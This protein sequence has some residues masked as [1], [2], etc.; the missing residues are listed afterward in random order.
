MPGS[1]KKI[2]K[3]VKKVIKKV[4]RKRVVFKAPHVSGNGSYTFND[5]KKSIDKNIFNSPESVGVVNKAARS[6][7]EFFGNKIHPVAGKV[8]GNA[9]SWLSRV[10][11]FGAYNIKSNSLARDGQMNISDSGGPSNIPE[12]RS[13]TKNSVR[14]RHR[15][16]VTDIVPTA[17]GFQNNNYLIHAGNVLL[18]PWL[19]NMS[20]NF[21]VAQIHGMIIE[22]KATCAT[23]VSSAQIGMGTVIMAT[24]YDVVDTAYA[25]KREMEIC[26]FATS[27]QPYFSQIHPIECD[28]HENVLSKHYIQY[29][30]TSVSDFPDD[31][32]FGC[33]GNFQIATNNIP[34]LNQAIGELWVSYDVEFFKPQLPGSNSLL[35]QTATTH[36]AYQVSN[37][38]S[39]SDTQILGTK[40]QPAIVAPL[41]VP[42]IANPTA[43]HSQI[44][45]TFGTPGDYMVTFQHSDTSGT[46][47]AGV[48]TAT[49][50]SSGCTYPFVATTSAGQDQTS[51]GC[52]ESS[53]FTN[54]GVRNLWT[55]CHYIRVNAAG[56][57]SGIP[58]NYDTSEDMY[59]DMWITTVQSSITSR[60]RNPSRIE[61]ATL[62]TQN[63][64]QIL[65]ERLDRVSYFGKDLQTSEYEGSDNEDP[66][67]T[68]IGIESSK[69]VV[70]LGNNASSS[71]CS[72]ISYQ[73]YL[74]WKNSQKD[75]LIS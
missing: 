12:F 55:G 56:G 69:N 46:Y 7:G 29:G 73:D 45:L 63:E 41:A 52:A 59:G 70:V 31:P 13:S 36:I 15:E 64:L 9:A 47:S 1:K 74:R 71:S 30:A 66:S 61:K 43:A 22:Y 51:F 72:D 48:S 6:V 39:L 50:V 54:S 35:Q 62:A 23:A 65:K 57:Q 58:L 24:D 67:Y 27:N 5:F 25:N 60:N 28:P 37:G 38:S 19:A 42:T 33:L 11:G 16:F 20:Q 40:T 32:R 21:E 17:A 44:I 3:K 10:F 18:W 34:V 75:H 2:M 8:I 68:T 14:V 49:P 4:A 26:E 53:S